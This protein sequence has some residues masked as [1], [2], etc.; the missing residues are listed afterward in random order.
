MAP[1]AEAQRRNNQPGIST[2]PVLVLV[3][4]GRQFC[5]TAADLRS[6]GLDGLQNKPQ[7]ASGLFLG[8][9]QSTGEKKNPLRVDKEDN[10][11][12][13]RP[14]KSRESGGSGLC[15]ARRK[16]LLFQ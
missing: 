2:L 10:K 6:W 7:A 11:P 13:K 9:V 14:K 3:E 16:L 8:E 1:M 15:G 12:T 5:I 4:D